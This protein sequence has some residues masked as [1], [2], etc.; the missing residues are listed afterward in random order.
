MVFETDLALFGGDRE[1]VAAEADVE[2]IEVGSGK[3]FK[4]FA[5][6][7]DGAEFATNGGWGRVS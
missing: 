1:G 7:G 5:R 6:S 2:G 3:E 4:V